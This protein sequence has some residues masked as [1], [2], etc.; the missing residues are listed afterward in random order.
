[1]VNN[2]ER[3]TFFG[4]LV[5]NMKSRGLP[6]NK[7]RRI[8]ILFIIHYSLFTT[9]FLTSCEDEF[10]KPQK[11]V[12]YKGPVSEIY[13]I[14]M[15]YSDSAKKMVSME[16]AVQ[17]QYLTEDKTYPKEVR[18]FFFDKTGKQTSTLRSDS[19]HYYRDKNYYK[20]KGNVVVINTV[21][22]ETLM[23]DELI[24]RPDDKKI[25]TDHDVTLRTREEVLYAKGMD[26]N[27]DFSKYTLRKVTGTLKA[28]QGLE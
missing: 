2:L 13:N 26:A 23:T 27:Q 22:G 5:Q 11:T 17:Y 16:T 4:K 25:F 24:W 12:K 6:K 10:G 3:I 28:P 20:V 14:K 7:W 15:T 1:M 21:K 9:F 8:K 19:A 18:V